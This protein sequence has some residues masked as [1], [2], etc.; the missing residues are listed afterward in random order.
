MLF[1]RDIS[2]E[3][4]NAQYFLDHTKNEVNKMKTEEKTIEELNQLLKGTHMG[5]SIFEDLRSKLNS[6]TLNKEFNEILFALHTHEKSLTALII[7]EKGEPIDSAGLLGSIT[8]MI[9]HIKNLSL[10]SDKEILEEA[11]KNMKSADKALKE[12]NQRH[13]VL[14]PNMEKT[15]SIMKEDYKSILHKLE[16]FTIEF[17]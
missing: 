10:T 16:R 2:H 1:T 11:A 9:S 7:S 15:I 5:A 4:W 6:E 3:I 17:Q 12:F 13:N 14:N 8:D